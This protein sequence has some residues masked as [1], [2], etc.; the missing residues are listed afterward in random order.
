MYSLQ[1]GK[2]KVVVDVAA[3][4]AVTIIVVLGVVGDIAVIVVGL[5]L[6]TAAVGMATWHLQ[7]TGQAD[8]SSIAQNVFTSSS[9]AMKLK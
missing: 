3:V 9:E 6:D 1:L 5:V 4:V 8:A 2:F 7:R